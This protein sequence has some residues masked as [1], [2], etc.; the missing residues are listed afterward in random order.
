[1]LTSSDILRNVLQL[2]TGIEKTIN[3][4]YDTSSICCFVTGLSLVCDM[5]EKMPVL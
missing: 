4:F 5:N 1:M 2:A 3:P